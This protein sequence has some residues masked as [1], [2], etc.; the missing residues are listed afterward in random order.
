MKY[1]HTSQNS[2]W[3]LKILPKMHNASK[4]I[5]MFLLLFRCYATNF[6]CFLCSLNP[7]ILLCNFYTLLLY[8]DLLVV[9]GSFFSQECSDWM[10]KTCKWLAGDVLRLHTQ[11]WVLAHRKGRS[12][13]CQRWVCARTLLSRFKHTHHNLSFVHVEI[14]AQGLLLC[15]QSSPGV[16]NTPFLSVAWLRM[17]LLWLWMS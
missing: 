10:K 3:N 11:S 9:I 7:A 14:W 6:Q 15:L 17:K 12:R 16:F 5:C 4:H 2:S 1:F 13:L 8:F